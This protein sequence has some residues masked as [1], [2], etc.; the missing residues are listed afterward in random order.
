MLTHLLNIFFIVYKEK[1]Q[2]YKNY[3]YSSQCLNIKKL[4]SNL[5]LSVIYPVMKLYNI[6][7]LIDGVQ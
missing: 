2:L 6:K 7:K 1:L 3:K 5:Q 4:D